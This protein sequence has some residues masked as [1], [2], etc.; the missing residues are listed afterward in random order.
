MNKKKLSIIAAGTALAAAAVVGYA[1]FGWKGLGSVSSLGLDLSRPDALV[2]TS[3]LSTL[4]RDLLTI[5]LARDVL[6][7][8]FLFY[9]EQGEDRLGLKGTLRRIA[10]EHELNWGDQLIRMVLDEP[11]DVALW[12]DADGSLKHF[13]I[14]VSRNTLTRLLEESAKIS[15]KDSQMMLAGSL[16][17]DGDKVPVYALA[18]GY[19]RTLL[20]AAHGKRL[21]ILS[22]PGM[23]YGGDDGKDADGRAEDVVEDMLSADS[24]RQQAF[25]RQFKLAAQAVAGHS[26]AVKADFL[27][28]GYQPFFGAL[29]ALRFDFSK[30]RWST[31]ALI[32]AARLPAGGYDNSHLWPA[33]PHNPAACFALPTDWAAMKP[34]LDKVGSKAG[35]KDAGLL[36][37]QLSGPAAVCWYGSSKL[38]T[39]LVVATLKNG[40][41]ADALLGGLF[42]AAVGNAQSGPVSKTA[43]KNGAVLWQRKV[44]TPAG[45]QTP[46]LALSGQTVLFSPDA[47]LVDLA[48]S[49]GRKQAAAL[50][51]R[52]PE[53]GRTV[54]VIAPS[55]LSTLMLK[56][57]FAAL[58]TASEPVLRLSADTHL[59]PRLEAL[60]KY[61]PYRLV[62]PATPAAGASWQPLEWQAQDK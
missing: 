43:G 42:G 34:V 44:A 40:A 48:L 13:A 50:S 15:L 10:Y 61:P 31:A 55:A 28:F 26:V 18:Y 16:K 2:V 3:S 9:Y 8:D 7:E 47:A 54:A 25:H 58:P 39:P 56:E 62:L 27:S 32:D 49:V 21:V 60:K 22:H 20:F 4:P 24:A 29:D 37:E 23:L 45:Q 38:Y 36:A 14:A 53:S 41:L 30:G 5:P 19:K 59:V 51:D 46:T 52:L 12:R 11:A 1:A 6:R 57:T 33:L 17:V 35:E